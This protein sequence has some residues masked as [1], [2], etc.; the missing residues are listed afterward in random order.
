M[1]ALKSELADRLVERDRTP[2]ASRRRRARLAQA[3]AEMRAAVPGYRRLAFAEALEARARALGR[4]HRLRVRTARRTRCPRGET[5]LAWAVREATT[6]VV[7]HSGARLLR[8]PSRRR[9]ASRARGRR[10]RRGARRRRRERARGSR[11]AGAARWRHAR[12]RRRA[13]R[14]ASAAAHGAAAPHVIRVLLAE[15]QAMVRGALASLLALEG[16]IEVVAQVARGDEVLDAARAH[17]PDVALLDIEM[18]GLR[19][20]RGGGAAARRSCPAARA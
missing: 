17:E 13:R 12:G 4:R 7:R 16:D 10:R 11:R 3:L 19:R 20:P 18:P 14:A 2:P 1:V 6:N 9:R 5:V 15:D 8:S